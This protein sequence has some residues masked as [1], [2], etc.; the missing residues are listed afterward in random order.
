MGRD[1]LLGLTAVAMLVHISTTSKTA[2]G[3]LSGPMVVAMRGS[4]VK[5]K[6]MVAASSRMLSER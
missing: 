6:C 2:M 1:N 5:E 4:S 3:G